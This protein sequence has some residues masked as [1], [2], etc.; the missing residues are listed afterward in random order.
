MWKNRGIP[1]SDKILNVDKHV[2]KSLYSVDN[3]LIYP[4]LST[5]GVIPK[6]IHRL[7]A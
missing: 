3:P 7:L 2:D 4:Q 6:I 5:D 1:V